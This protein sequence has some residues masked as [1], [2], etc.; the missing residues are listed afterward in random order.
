MGKGSQGYHGELYLKDGDFDCKT[1]IKIGTITDFT[2]TIKQR[3]RDTSTHG[4]LAKNKNYKCFEGS[5]KTW[6]F[7]FNNIYIDNTEG[8]EKLEEV[9]DE[10]SRI[11][12]KIVP[13]RNKA[14][15]DFIN[16][17]I[18]QALITTSSLKNSL[19]TAVGS[20]INLLGTGPIF[21]LKQFDD[22]IIDF[23]SGCIET[24]IANGCDL[25][26][27]GTVIDNVDIASIIQPPVQPPNLGLPPD[28]FINIGTQ[29]S[30]S[31]PVGWS[32]LGDL[33]L[34]PSGQ[35]TYS[36]WDKSFCTSLWQFAGYS[37]PPILTEFQPAPLSCIVPGSVFVAST[38][39]DF[40]EPIST[41]RSYLVPLPTAKYCLIDSGLAAWKYNALLMLITEFTDNG[42]P[43]LGK[44]Y[45]IDFSI[46]FFNKDRVK[47]A[48]FNMDTYSTHDA[49][50]WFDPAMKD[51][52]PFGSR[53]WRTIITWRNPDMISSVNFYG[54]YGF[55]LDYR[56]FDLGLRFNF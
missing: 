45:S 32:P 10:G 28:D 51:A 34:V 13:N 41:Q 2:L 42:A 39:G 16:I 52:V 21:K 38:N 3:L 53:Y 23:E 35:S 22:C 29:Y 15:G 44:A 48:E 12:L 40:F 43:T 11:W 20:S 6:S 7:I 27:I 4:T 55:F 5:F 18:G 31:A 50:E 30:A 49:N 46:Q 54:V 33:S 17:F 25:S 26:Q 9:I 8:R 36:F 56:T 19:Q 14:S 47:I 1:L 37:N 24:A